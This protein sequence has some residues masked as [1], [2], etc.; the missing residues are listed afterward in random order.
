[1]FIDVLPKRT[2]SLQ[3]S[4]TCFSRTNVSLLTELGSCSGSGFYK[5]LVPLGPKTQW[6]RIDCFCCANFGDKTLAALLNLHVIPA[7]GSRRQ[8]KAWGVSPKSLQTEGP[9]PAEQATVWD[10]NRSRLKHHAL[11][12]VT[13]AD[14][15]LRCF[16][17]AHAPGFMLSPAT[18]GWNDMKVHE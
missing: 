6:S 5:H 2:A 15:H 14:S 18:A 9:E 17:G 11:P 13:R 8:H 1:M 7:C 10:E 3:R 16:P 4:E 12:P